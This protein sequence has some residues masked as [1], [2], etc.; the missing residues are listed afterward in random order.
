MNVI[1]PYSI[2]D[3]KKIV[4]QKPTPNKIPYYNSFYRLLYN[5]E[6]YTLQ[7]I[8][9]EIPPGYIITNYKTNKITISNSF[10]YSL[11]NIEQSILKNINHIT[12]KKIERLLYNDCMYRRYIANLNEPEH[13]IWL[14]LSG[15]WESNDKIGMTYK[16]I[17]HR[18]LP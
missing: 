1:I 14:R 11:S 2:F 15:I 8:L 10:L 12:N 7:N 13:P 6:H 17:Q 3:V 4:F 16:F 18:Y 9:I 5:E